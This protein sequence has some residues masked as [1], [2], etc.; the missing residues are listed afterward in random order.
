MALDVDLRFTGEG[1]IR[2]VHHMEHPGYAQPLAGG[3]VCAGH[4]EG[5]L[6]AA[7][8]R[9]SSMRSRAGKRSRWLFR[10]WRVSWKG[11]AYLRADGYQVTVYQRGNGWGTTIGIPG[12]EFVQHS[13]RNYSTEDRAKLAGFDQITKLLN[14][15]D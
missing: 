13:R 5:D 9:E 6:L 2:F 10:K 14:G 3:C 8:A 12:T 4:M 1:T 11:N 7:Q 15:R